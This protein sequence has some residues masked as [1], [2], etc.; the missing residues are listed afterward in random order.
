MIVLVDYDNVPSSIRSTEF[1]TVARQLAA[2]LVRHAPAVDGRIDIRLYGG[3]AD[4]AGPSRS[5]VALATSIAA[6]FP[7]PYVPSK[8]KPQSVNAVLAESLLCAPQNLLHPTVLIDRT[9]VGRVKCQSD[10]CCSR[11]TCPLSPMRPFFADRLCPVDDCAITPPDVIDAPWQQKMVDSMIVADA[12]YLA[13]SREPCIAIASNDR[14][15]IPALV[16]AT[17]LGVHVI[18]MTDLRDTH[19]NR[20][21]HALAGAFDTI[22]LTETLNGRC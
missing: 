18:H 10:F 20:Q 1:Q 16:L 3:W 21:R 15:A 17:A 19:F 2:A 6:N 9:F 11:T 5:R 22:P 7:F 14:D 12:A 4:E 13:M 8:G